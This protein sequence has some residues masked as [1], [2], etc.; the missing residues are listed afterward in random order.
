MRNVVSGLG[1]RDRRLTKLSL[2]F[3]RRPKL[4]A[5]VWLGLL[6]FGI[7][8]YTTLL[9]RQ[10][11]PPVQ[12][13]LS[14]VTGGYLVDDAQ[15][16]DEQIDKPISE[17]AL[18]QADVKSVTAAANANTFNI[19]IEYKDGT[20]PKA[21]SQKLQDA[22]VASGRLPKAAKP[23]FQT[24]DVSKYSPQ[25]EGFEILIAFY[26]NKDQ[27]TEQLVAKAR[28]YSAQL[29]KQQLSL[30]DTTKVIDPFSEGVDPQTGQSERIQ[31][32]FDRYGERV[33]GRNVF[34]NDVVIGLKAK[35]SADTIKLDKQVVSALS[36][37]NRKPQFA[38]Y[39]AAVT[40]T[41][42][43]EIQQDVNELQKT[44]L[45]GLIA[46][47]IIGTVLIAWRASV[48]IILSIATVI[49][50]TFGVLYLIG[51][52]VNVITLFSIILGLALIV[53]DT[54]IMTEAIDVERRRQKNAQ[55]TVRA[56][57]NKVS[58][59]MLAATTTA[60][61]A[62]A[63]IIFITGILGGFIR[64]IPITIISSLIIS[65]FVALIIIPFVARSLI[66]RKGNIGPRAKD[67][68][69]VRLQES[70]AHKLTMPL[71]WANHSR[72]RLWL[73]G[74]VA[75]VVGLSFIFGGIY[76]FK[77][78]TFNIFPSNK[79]SNLLTIALQ[80][81]AGTDINKAQ[82][83]TDKADDI[84]SKT[85]GDNF[86][87]LTY[88]PQVIANTNLAEAVIN[89]KPYT[90]RNITAPQLADKLKA[91]FK[92]FNQ[93][94][95]TIS[96]NDVGGP[97]GVFSVL[98]ETPDRANA[99]K[100]AADIS[101]FLSGRE[102]KRTDGSTAHI[103]KA[104]VSNPDAY[105]RKNSHQNVQVSAEFD[106]DDT[107]TLF[108]LAKKAVQKQYTNQKLAQYHL[109]TKNLVYDTGFEE[110]NQKS[111][112]S[113]VV[114]FPILLVVMYLVL[115]LEFR[116]LLQPLLIFMAI[117]FSFFGVTGGLWLTDNPFSFFTMLGFFA[118]IGL[119]IKNTILLTDYANQA[120]RAGLGRV[121]AI[122]S[123][124]EERFRPLLATSATAVFSLLPLA[125]TSPFWESLAF[126]LIFGLLSSTALVLLVF[127]YYYLGG[128]YLRSRIGVKDFFSW[129]IPNIV[130]LVVVSKL[131]GG[132]A[133]LPV[134]VIFNLLVIF[135]KIM[136][137]KYKK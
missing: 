108:D 17:I 1:A 109:S 79:D 96:S 11:F 71:R 45:E 124:V 123:A 30:V 87:Q 7:L 27:S 100:L 59:A 21:A 94:S 90:D 52:T 135:G 70:F 5:L 46:V 111:F 72:K 36:N 99:K 137:R 133:V 125:L 49:A 122:A 120:R 4:T 9:G 6:A 106:G 20:E 91:N 81:P 19:L 105:L 80:F 41:F 102:L 83:V 116:S 92:D 129:L 82:V 31:T 128:E 58:L 10:G 97:P 53:D 42:A 118:L 14:I 103:T 115:A 98:I 101:Q 93:A 84:I 23:T 127:P 112:N 48:L 18:K 134:F 60:I 34:H 104:L 35:A 88:S 119:S 121:E 38:D 65:L 54:I 8:S 44:L 69:P 56:A 132:K 89:I 43:T 29:N 33:N 117:P 107:T 73:S 26:G 25:G 74:V 32:G 16:V 12:A 78:L 50:V 22:V 136:K 130:I 66:L 51:Y 77:Y 63:P 15:K 113:M 3:F 114:A 55:Q 62:F 47:F 67:P 40:A 39:K 131:A 110:D 37:L 57:T 24:F 64:P 28:E 2:F 13:P 68:L 85:L 75:L 61:L 76:I 126:T 86:E 95:I